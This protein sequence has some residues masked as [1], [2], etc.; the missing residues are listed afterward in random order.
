ME[1]LAIL[2]L[3][4]NR[5]QRDDV[6]TLKKQTPASKTEAGVFVYSKFYYS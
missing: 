3:L 2:L 6:L 4:G 5:R 1:P